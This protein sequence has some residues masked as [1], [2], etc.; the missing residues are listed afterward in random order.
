MIEETLSL[1]PSGFPREVT[2]SPR[3]LPLLLNYQP[4]YAATWNLGD[5]V[6]SLYEH[7]SIAFDPWN[8]SHHVVKPPMDHICQCPPCG[9]F[10]IT[11]N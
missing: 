3:K 9:L 2:S 5:L 1:Q 6:S 7:V 11:W 8:Q 4:R 10:Q